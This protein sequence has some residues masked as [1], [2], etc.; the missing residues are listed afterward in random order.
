M[1]LSCPICEGKGCEECG[2]SGERHRTHID[3]GDGLRLSVTGDRALTEA[4]R[5]ALATIA[6]LAFEK[7]DADG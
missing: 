6:R 3:A 4:G 7:M 5:D 2:Q 1:V